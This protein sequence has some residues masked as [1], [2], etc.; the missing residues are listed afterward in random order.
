LDEKQKQKQ[1]QDQG[2]DLPLVREEALPRRAQ[3]GDAGRRK[4]TQISTT[5]GGAWA[6][7]WFVFGPDGGAAK[8]ILGAAGL[9]AIAAVRIWLHTH[10]AKAL[11]I[12]HLNLELAQPAARRG[13]RVQATLTV[14]D[15]SRL[16]GQLRATI[17]CTETYDYRV[18]SNRDNRG[19]R[20]RKR[21]R[22]L[23]TTQVPIADGGAL[24]FDLPRELPPTWEGT[25]VK[26]RWTLTVRE[27]VERGLD[28]TIE[29][30]LQVL[31]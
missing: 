1:K 14:L 9:V 30:P 29:M 22:E 7:F 17:A 23:W 25:I 13:D 6:F 2:S 12:S 20:R 18:D 10:G 5:V 16:R 3:P 28:P 26:Y 21:T 24:L 19:P 15:Q 11:D 27:H 31:P 8:W 4:I